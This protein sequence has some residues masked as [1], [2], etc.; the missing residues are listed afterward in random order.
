[1]ASGLPTVSFDYAASA[2]HIRDGE[3]GLKVAFGDEDAFVDA[4][5]RLVTDDAL[6]AHVGQGAL[7]T[8][9]S[10]GWSPIVDT[11]ESTL[12]QAIDHRR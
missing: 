8:M 1:M 7:A 5:V 9:A 11:F 6:R 3:N 2:I 12:E 4:T 10:L